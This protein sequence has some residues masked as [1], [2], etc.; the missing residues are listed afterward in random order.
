MAGKEAPA[1]RRLF[2]GTFLPEADKQRLGALKEH[3]ER[4]GAE[5]KRKLR[6]V[7]EDKL[8]LTWLF[9]GYVEEQSI[10]EIKQRLGVLVKGQGPFHLDY[11]KGVFWPNARF[12][13]M[14]VLVPDAV[15]PAVAEFAALVK[16]ELKEFLQKDEHRGYRPH[17][18]LIRMDSG[19]RMRMDIPEWFPLSERLPI[20][21]SIKQVDLIESHM[22]HGKDSYESLQSY[23]LG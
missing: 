6:F 3:G 20:H 5:W 15:P 2:V 11:T 12:P 13:G 9:L 14:L 21:H 17:I 19:P 7:R 1:K 16:K 18:T 4:L 10:D 23:P 22:G 8:H